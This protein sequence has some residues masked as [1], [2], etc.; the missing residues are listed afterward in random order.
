MSPSYTT[1]PS[2]GLESEEKVR[3]RGFCTAEADAHWA[4]DIS[5]LSTGFPELEAARLRVG[6]LIP[7]PFDN[8]IELHKQLSESEALLHQLARAKKKVIAAMEIHNQ[9]ND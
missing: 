4:T 6:I 8:I 1:R 9:R 5:V 7:M 2:R 3:F